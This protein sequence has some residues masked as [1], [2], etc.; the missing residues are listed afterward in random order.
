MAR[1]GFAAHFSSSRPALQRPSTEAAVGFDVVEYVE[2]DARWWG[3]QWVQA[4]Q[5]YCW[6]L[7]AE[8]VSRL[9]KVLWRHPWAVGQGW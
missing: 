4:R 6:W 9:G 5:R 2:C 1:A 8:D 7:A 3:C